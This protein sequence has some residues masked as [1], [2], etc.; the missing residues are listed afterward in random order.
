MAQARSRNTN[1]ASEGIIGS[2][3][4]IRGRVTGEGDLTVQGT[5]E[6]DIILRGRLTIGEGASVTSNVDAESVTIEG[7]LEG[8]VSARGPV[9]IA[10]GSRVKGDVKGSQIAVEE[11]AEF[12]G[13]LDCD[14]ELPAEMGG[15]ETR[16]APRKAR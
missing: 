3:A 10:A 16:G 1:G 9:R 6:G 13:R 14:F 5:V 7:T 11:G 15:Q 12:A 8:D 2:G 4:K